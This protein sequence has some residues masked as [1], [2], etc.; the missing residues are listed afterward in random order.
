MGLKHLLQPA[1]HVDALLIRGQSTLQVAD[2][3]VRLA[4]VEGH[5]GIIR[6]LCLLRLQ[7]AQVYLQSISCSA[8]IALLMPAQ[9][10]GQGGESARESNS[11]YLSKFSRHSFSCAAH[12]LMSI[13]H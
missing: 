1:A 4:E 11:S 2:Q 3:V 8:L 6:F 12:G 10:V 7:Q 9:R 13:A 5:P